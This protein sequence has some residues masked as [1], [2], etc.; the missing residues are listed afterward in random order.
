MDPHLQP[1]QPETTTKVYW[2]DR[3]AL[4][5]C[6]AGSLFIWL[7]ALANLAATLLRR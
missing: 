5:V 6:L 1:A 4:Q 2:G 3:I 7:L